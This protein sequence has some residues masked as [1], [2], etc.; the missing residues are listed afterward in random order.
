VKNDGDKD[1]NK[2]LLFSKKDKLT[3]AFMS[4]IS[5]VRDRLRFY[6]ITVADKN[7]NADNVEL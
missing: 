2:V 1:I 7:P 3:P 4:A 6:V 5:E